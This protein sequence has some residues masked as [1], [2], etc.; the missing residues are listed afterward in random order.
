PLSVSIDREDG[1]TVRAF[2]YRIQSRQNESESNQVDR[3]GADSGQGIW[4]QSSMLAGNHVPDL[5][6]P[7]HITGF[8]II[9]NTSA[10]CQESA[11]GCW[12]RGVGKSDPPYFLL[13]PR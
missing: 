2:I 10:D 7:Q 1:V 5:G 6:D 9:W 13:V 8:E 4:P 3:R 11:G 12:E